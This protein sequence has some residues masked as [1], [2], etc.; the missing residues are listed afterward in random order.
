MDVIF[1]NKQVTKYR[2]VL[3]AC[4]LACLI[5][6]SIF[7]LYL[8]Y[9]CMLGWFLVLLTSLFAS[10]HQTSDVTLSMKDNSGLMY[11]GVANLNWSYGANPS[12]Q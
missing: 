10:A 12:N 2:L 4:L 7:L 5:A 1:Q 11:I 3:F 8:I 6:Y 9:L